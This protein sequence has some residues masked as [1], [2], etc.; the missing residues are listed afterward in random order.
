M[1]YYADSATISMH[2]ATPTCWADSSIAERAAILVF[3]LAFF[4]LACGESTVPAS[5]NH[6]AGR[7]LCHPRRADDENGMRRWT[8]RM[9]T[10]LVIG[11]LTRHGPKPVGHVVSS[12][13]RADASQLGAP[14]VPP[15]ARR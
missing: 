3:L 6:S 13:G 4:F 9:V 7:L 5:L 1:S 11:A 8:T 12:L 15:S 10:F 14:V 2:T